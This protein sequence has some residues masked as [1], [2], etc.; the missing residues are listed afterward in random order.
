MLK[1]LK[2]GLVAKL[3]DASD[4]KSEVLLDVRVQ[5]PSWPPYL[6]S[7]QLALITLWSAL[8]VV[9]TLTAEFITVRNAIV[10]P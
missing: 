10:G 8:F 3:A 5:V 1:N 2:P 6:E 7:A 9:E 4:S